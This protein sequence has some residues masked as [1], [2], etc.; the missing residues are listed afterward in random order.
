MRLV[1]ALFVL[2]LP[3]CTIGYY[4]TEDVESDPAATEPA[5]ADVADAAIPP[6]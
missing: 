3:A 2:L 6:G 4:G 1:L 5:P